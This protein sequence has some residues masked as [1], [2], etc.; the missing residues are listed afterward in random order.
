MK[1]VYRYIGS[2]FGV[3]VLAVL[4]SLTV[5]P[6]LSTHAASTAYPVEA[7]VLTWTP[8]TSVVSVGDTAASNGN[9]LGVVGAATGTATGYTDALQQVS[10]I[11]RGNQC[12][13]APALQVKLDGAVIGTTTVSN[14][15]W[16]KYDYPVAVPA[17]THQF[18]IGFTNPYTQQ[19]FGWTICS[20][21]L[22]IDGLELHVGAAEQPQPTIV[23]YAS[24]GDSYSSGMGSEKTPLTPANTGVYDQSSGNCYRSSISAA[25]LLASARNFTLNDVSCA[26]ATTYNILTSGQ[27][28]QPAQ[29]TAVTA[30]TNL[31]TLTIGGNDVGLLSFISCAIDTE[32]TNASSTTQSIRAGI[33]QLQPKIASVLSAIK[34]AAP[35]AQ[36][37]IA[38]YPYLL[39]SPDSTTTGNCTVA[40]LD[41]VRLFDELIDQTNA[42]IRQA[43]Q[44]A[45][46]SVRYVDPVQANSP[47]M[48]R[49]NGL[50]RGACSTNTAR[51][52]NGPTDG[53]GYWHPNAGG[54]NAYYTL[55]NNSL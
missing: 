51:L 42:A 44:V 22:V 18:S 45:G 11:V 19:L 52:F 27:N 8:S 37:R 23:K 54:F 25:R 9:A 53:T 3:M 12:Q 48:Q 43:A 10:V 14:G 36:I 20:R 17:G 16:A 39:S 15:G 29:I 55:Y 47:F 31:V 21:S 38:G 32:C 41:E 5:Q 1:R 30:Q 6:A 34:S 33:A 49:D 35:T 7:E 13:G 24:L 26:G 2:L 40:S 4:A 46:N 28:G 50:D